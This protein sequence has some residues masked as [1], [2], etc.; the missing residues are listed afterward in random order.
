MSKSDT[1]KEANQRRKVTKAFSDLIQAEIDSI[2]PEESMSTWL[3]N[4]GII[5]GSETDDKGNFVL[6]VEKEN[7]RMFRLVMTPIKWEKTL[8]RKQ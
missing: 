6:F 3:D 7:G 5:K 4:I 8:G 1:R 2:I